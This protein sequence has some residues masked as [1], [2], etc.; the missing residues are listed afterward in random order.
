MNDIKAKSGKVSP[1]RIVWR[2]QM[3]KGLYTPHRVS[4]ITCIVNNEVSHLVQDFLI[5]L[6]VDVYIESG[7][8]VREVVKPLPFGIP[9]DTVKLNSTSATIFRFSVPRENARLVI[10]AVVALAK[11]NIPGRGTIFSQDLMEFSKYPPEIN[12]N[13][14]E[15]YLMESGDVNLLNRLSYM[16]CVLSENGSGDKLAKYALDLGIC[17]PLLTNATGNDIRDQL[18]L[19]R[20]T[21]PAEK[22]VVHLVVPEHD[23]ASIAY[24]LAEH[25]HLDR[26]GRGFIYQTPVTVGLVDTHMKIGG[27][28]YSASM[29]QVICAIDSLKGDTSWRRRL[30]TNVPNGNNYI[31]YDNCEVSIIS[32]EDRIDELR[33]TCLNVGATGATT[34][35]IT[36]LANADGSNSK[37]LLVRCAVSIPANMADAVVDSLLQISD[38]EKDNVDKINVLDSPSTYVRSI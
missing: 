25:S 6:G 18:G 10:E 9:G 35:R 27:Q 3:A 20:V 17:V 32:D 4:L 38:I 36:L 2:T 1:S 15:D 13:V 30:D 31:K 7:R 23:S 11:L 26:P 33:A 24:L 22:E 14:L 12:F 19:I 29:E 21:I 5:R 16:I 8:N 28:K 34:S 37:K